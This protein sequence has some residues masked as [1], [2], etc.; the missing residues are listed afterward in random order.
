MTPNAETT[1]GTAPTPATPETTASYLLLAKSVERP[2]NAAPDSP[3][4]EIFAQVLNNTAIQSGAKVESKSIA[5]G[6]YDFVVEITVDVDAY[7][8]AT[9]KATRPTTQQ[10]A[11]GIAAALGHNA[12]VKTE[13]LPVT[14]L[15]DPIVADVVH[16]CTVSLE[17]RDPCVGASQ[18]SNDSRTVKLNDYVD[19]A[20]LG[21]APSEL[22]A[23]AISGEWGMLGNKRVGDCTFAAAGHAIQLWAAPSNPTPEIGDSAVMNAYYEARKQAHTSRTVNG[24]I[25]P[26]SAGVT[27]TAALN[28]W[29]LTGIGGHQIVAFASVPRDDRAWVRYAIATFKCVYVV[30]ALPDAVVRAGMTAETAPTWNKVPPAG[31]G[32]MLSLANSHCVI[33]TGYDDLGVTAIT[34]GRPM[35][36]SWEFHDDYCDEMYVAFPKELQGSLGGVKVKQ[37]LKAAVAAAK[38]ERPS[39]VR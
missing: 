3:A 30:L 2:R 7:V 38:T 27:A 8:K 1:A 37:W 23:P 14:Q 25:S 19:A 6:L 31:P 39:S 16:S 26:A 28:Y 17:N 21:N 35:R 13:T 22:T 15:D 33:Y 34:W 12:G 24:R 10:I 5:Q 4:I 18:R 36:T 20:E 11:L 32:A 9:G 29:R